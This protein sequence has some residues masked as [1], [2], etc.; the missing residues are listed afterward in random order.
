[1]LT[2]FLA[3]ALAGAPQ[4]ST[5]LVVVAT[6]D[7]RGRAMGWDYVADAPASGGVARVAAIIDSLRGQYAGQV[8]VVDAGDVL[9]GDPFAT[10]VG[11][12]APRDP[13]PVVEA[14]NLAGYDAGTPG[15]R[16]FDLGFDAMRRALAGAA[17]PYVSANL[18]TLQ[19][20]TLLYPALAILRRGEVRVAV[21]GF[22]SSDA[23]TRHGELGSRVRIAPIGEVAAGALERAR[24]LADV[25]IALVH[26]DRA[27]EVAAVAAGRAH[28]DLIVTG[29][30][31]DVLPDSIG[32]DVPVAQPGAAAQVAVI[33]LWLG[34]AGGT[35]RVRRTRVDMVATDRVAAAPR[36]ATRLAT[37]HAAARTWAQ[38]PI[39]WS[40][41]PFTAADAR[42][43]S[44]ALVDFV[45]LVERTRA[46][47]DLAATPAFSLA[48]GLP[49]RRIRRADVLALYPPDYT[50]V[51]VKI[52]GAQLKAYL[53]HAARYFQVDAVGRVGLSDSMPGEDFDIVG[54]AHYEIDLHAP[55]GARIRGLAVRGRP[56][57]PADS[58]TL[59]LPRDRQAGAGGY[60]LAGAPVVYDRGEYIRDLLVEEI[61]RH[62]SLDPA[63]YLEPGWRI[64]PTASAVAVRALFNL[65][66]PPPPTPAPRDSTVLRV[67]ALGGVRG[68]FDALPA[69]KAV[70]DSLAR[71]CA[72]GTLRLEAGDGV[73]AGAVASAAAAGASLDL[74]ARLGL[75]AAVPGE[76]ELDWPPDTAR[77]HAAES[78]YPWLAANVFAATGDRPT[79]GNLPYWSEPYRIVDAGGLRVAV[80]GYV[81]AEAAGLV[82]A[83]RAA[84]L[85]VVE[86]ML[87]LRAVLDEVRAARP[88]FTVLL[89]HGHGASLAQLADE[90]PR[91][92]VDVVL[93]GPDVDTT[94]YRGRSGIAMVRVGGD[95]AVLVAVDVIRTVPGGRELQARVIA[96]ADVRPD[97]AL[98][99]VAGGFRRRA[100]S[101]ET[102][103]VA[104]IKLPLDRGDSRLGQ[105]VAEARRNALHAD[106]GLVRASELRGGLG[107]GPVAYRDLLRVPPSERTL[108]TVALSGKQLLR[109]FEQTLTDGTPS[110]RV[111]GLQIR[112]DPKRA[113]GRR[114]RRV[115]LGNGRELQ[116][117]SV[118]QVVV[119]DAMMSPAQGLT[120]L[121][122]GAAARSALLDADAL[123]RYLRRLPQ[124]VEVPDRPGFLL[125]GP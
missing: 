89:A 90:L 88:D 76:R 84:G 121:R 26:A 28:P 3:L 75:A 70:M 7:V 4:D 51:A 63:T 74:L 41:A 116:R 114:V 101:V 87:A 122:E 115:L 79:A 66:G 73:P 109:L 106:V 99:R 83:E 32:G 43:G 97:P 17:F 105:L 20:D 104:T 71:D 124:P 36:V 9:H 118:Y 34:R 1:M 33:H 110:V 120:V 68:R 16:D 85:H 58:F 31:R 64:V 39:G 113:A 108:V 119:D 72:C 56:V 13:H 49:L 24:E 62:E 50:L 53:E 60:D 40:V 102:A 23:M 18:F 27:R 35:W 69:I 6:A 98:A 38:A 19:G 80:I 15:D 78:G 11:R 29:R 21:T 112:Y 59:A 37:E 82:S 125:T 100:D 22:T 103:P 95:G 57:Q 123:V 47:A 52:S 46:G 86:G 25:V 65:P 2:A 67:L 54:G 10:Y 55:V 12:V 14:L 61:K 8:V 107:A 77:R 44:N 30:M 92:S 96:S 5:H 117:D 111:A 42:A 93:A 81:T 45:N 94:A 48:A 91:G